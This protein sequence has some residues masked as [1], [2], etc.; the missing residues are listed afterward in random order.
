M[1]APVK[2]SPREVARQHWG[3]PLPDWI[4]RLAEECEATSQRQAAERIR[5]SAGLVSNVLRN[6]YTGDMAGVEE[7]VRG[8]L[9]GDTVT[10]PELG[11]S[12]P[13]T[14]RSGGAAAGSTPAPTASGSGC[15]APAPAVR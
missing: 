10:C 15:S 12:R 11:P 9:M 13:T 3:E 2:A 8:A 6:R 1:S 7:A 4:A 5:Y 14:A